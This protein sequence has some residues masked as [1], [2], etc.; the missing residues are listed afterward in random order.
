ME[1]IKRIVSKEM[2]IYHP[3]AIYVKDL[4]EEDI[5]RLNFLSRTIHRVIILLEEG[6]FE[7]LKDLK[8][9]IEGIEFKDFIEYNQ[10]FAVECERTGEHNF[11]SMDV[12]KIVGR[13]IIEQYM[14]KVGNRLRVNLKN[15]DIL[16]RIRIR[17]RKYWI[18]IDTTGMESLAKR[19]YRVYNHPAA[20]KTTI[21]CCMIYLSK[22]S[23]QEKFLDPMCG[24]GTIPIEAARIAMNI[25]NRKFFMFQNFKFFDKDKWKKILSEHSIRNA[26]YNIEGF[27]ISP[28]HIEGAIRNSK[29]AGVNVRFYVADATKDSLDSDVIIFNPPYGIRMKNPR[30]VKKLY[31]KFCENA[32]KYDWKRM[33]LITASWEIFKRYMPNPKREIFCMNGDLPTK[34]L[35]Y[36]R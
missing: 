36:E 5:Y 10:T 27:D 22:W 8:K 30:F 11:T 33:V 24:S 2:F 4:C 20:L 31:M 3:G 14:L 18:G 29:S 1:E 35:I 13:I 12:E 16:I 25:P 23:I 6:E 15:P 32:S 28:K 7:D 26:E 17:H 9:K 34:I 19:N 21:A